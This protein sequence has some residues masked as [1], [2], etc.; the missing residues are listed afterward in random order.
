[1]AEDPLAGLNLSKTQEEQLSQAMALIQSMGA[2]PSEQEQHPYY[3]ARATFSE[4]GRSPATQSIGH[5][6]H[7]TDP[8]A[9]DKFDWVPNAV[10]QVLYSNGVIA[11]PANKQLVLPPGKAVLGSEPW[12]LKIQD[13]WSDK[14]ANEWR[15]RLAN[16]GYQVAEKGGM[17]HDLLDALRAYHQNRYLNYGKA[18]PLVP[19]SNIGTRESIRKSIDFKTLKSDIA[20]WGQVP[21][22]E[23]LN[24]TEA[25]YFADLMVRK[26]AELAR[27][28]P[29]WTGDQIQTGATTRVQE[30]FTSQPQVAGLLEEQEDQEVS[31][32]IRDSIV[33]LDQLLGA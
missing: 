18:Q 30:E 4:T 22:G 27:K 33:G 32:K 9:W 29:N 25:D 31:Y 24:D 19:T 28:H 17:A 16:D 21:F 2:A 23:D 10:G 3:A 14:E 12:I 8:E 1:M 6:M 13:E 7:E 26:M 15:K 5:M 11:D 20:A